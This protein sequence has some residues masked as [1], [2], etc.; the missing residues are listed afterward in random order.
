MYRVTYGTTD[1]LSFFVVTDEDKVLSGV[2][3]S[4]ATSKGL[5]FVQDSRAHSETRVENNPK[6]FTNRVW[7]TEKAVQ[8]QANKSKRGQATTGFGVGQ[9]K[10]RYMVR[11]S[12]IRQNI[13]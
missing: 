7:Y 9:V 12:E 5:C 1:F 8:K 6:R 3:E 4:G 11:R 2:E 13:Q 10:V